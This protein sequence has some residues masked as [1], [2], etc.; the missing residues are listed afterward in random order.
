MSENWYYVQNKNRQ[1]PVPIEFILGLI[2]KSELSQEDY[3]WKKG[4]DNWK[5]IKDAE[6][7]NLFQAPLDIPPQIEREIPN[8]TEL[9]LVS[10][11]GQERSYHLLIGLDRG[12]VP[13]AYGPYSLE[14]LKKLYKEKRINGKT[15][16][17]YSGLEEYKLLADFSDFEKVFNDIPPEIKE[18]ERRKSVRKPFIARMFLENNKKLYEGICRDVSIGGMQV[19][20]D[21]F[22]G[23][24]GEEISLNV[25]PENSDYHFVASGIIVRVLD[26]NAGFSFRFKKLSDEAKEAIEKF[27]ERN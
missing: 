4:F 11:H 25:H 26:G 17:F 14:V 1:G 5:K 13:L 20:L 10:N 15:Q 24:T 19:L 18:S 3:V 12:Q 16:V 9:T 22:N 21:N 8:A 2:E 23:K 7:L 27:I 6:E